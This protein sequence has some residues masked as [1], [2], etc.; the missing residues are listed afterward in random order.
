MYCRYSLATGVTKVRT[1]TKKYIAAITTG[2]VTAGLV[3]A[4][5][6]AAPILTNGG[7]EAGTFANPYNPVFAVNNATID[8]W[9]VDSGSVDLITTY[10]TSSEGDQSIDLNGWTPGSMSQA[11][12]T[13]VGHNYKVTFDLAGNPDGGTPLKTL[14]VSA[15]GGATTPYSFDTTGQSDSNMGWLPQTYSF[16]A[17]SAS[18]TL[19]FAS[20]TTSNSDP[21]GPALDNVNVSD[22]TPLLPTSKDQCKNDGW[23]TYGI[24]KNQG[25]CV[26]FVATNGRNLPSG[27]TF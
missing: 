3:A 10:W 27:P 23:K 1:N 8:G 17:N 12:P 11:F 22:V 6:F 9:T 21:F 2:I 25:D 15:T 19:T 18:T 7:F 4:P 5:A 16:T 14:N 24:F 13:I 26:S 20:T